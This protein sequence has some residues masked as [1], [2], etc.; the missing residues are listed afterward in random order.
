MATPPD[1]RIVHLADLPAAAAV[2]ADWFVAEWGPWYGPG[3]DGDAAADL[4]ARCRRDDLPLA[5]VAL[6]RDGGVLG[7]AALTAEPV[8]GETGPGPWLAALLVG[9]DH[10]GRGIGTALVAAIEAEARRLGFDAVYTSTDAADRIMARRGWQA[11][12]TAGSL[13]G[14]TTVFCRALDDD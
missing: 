6:D 4:A 1:I 9:T 13:R 5:L 2:L 11:V 12:G 3:G 10:R 14:P 8:A 7:T